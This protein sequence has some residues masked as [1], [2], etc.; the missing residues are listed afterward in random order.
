[1]SSQKKTVEQDQHGLSELKAPIPEVDGEEKETFMDALR[2][3]ANSIIP[4]IDQLEKLSEEQIDFIILDLIRKHPQKAF[5]N[6]CMTVAHEALLLKKDI[7]ETKKTLFSNMDK[8]ITK[9]YNDSKHILNK[10]REKKD[11]KS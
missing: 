7:I 6:I 9:I 11:D 2:R 5:E 4:V 1:M 10:Q 8:G 3:I